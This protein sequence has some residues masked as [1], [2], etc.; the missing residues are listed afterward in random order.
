MLFFVTVFYA[1]A[2]DGVDTS[3][4]I[5][6]NVTTRMELQFKFTQTFIFPVFAGMHPLT[7][8][9]NLRLDLS[10]DITPVSVNGTA[11]FVLTPVAFLQLV[12]G[13]AIGSGWNIPLADGLRINEPG[14]NPDG[15]LDGSNEL[16]GDAFD[17]FVWTVKGGGVF[18]FDL[19][20]VKPGDWNHVVFRTY[21][22]L[23]YRALTTAGADDSWVYENDTGEERN[24]WWY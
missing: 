2:E 21:H 3:Q 1:T 5:T 16:T 12:A 7:E 20:A 8:N 18:Q 23:R 9:N 13:G 4:L 14:R 11:E 17:G 6:V 19:A 24:G 10:A 15:T 22:G